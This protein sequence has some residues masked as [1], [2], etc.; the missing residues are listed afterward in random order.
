MQT[1]QSKFLNSIQPFAGWWVGLYFT[2]L[3]VIFTY[4][5]VWRMNNSVVGQIGD[6]IYFIWL[7]RWYNQAL[8][9]LHTN[10]FYIAHLNYP[11]GWYIATSDTVPAAMIYTLPLSWIGGATWAYNASMLLSFILSGLFMYL[12]IKESTG[13]RWSGLLSGTLFAFVP[14]HVEHFVA[15][16]LSLA[17]MQ[18]FPLYF[19]ALHRLLRAEQITWKPILVAAVS[20]GLISGTAPYYIYMT[21][22]FSAVFVLIWLWQE[23]NR[24]SRPVLWQNLALLGFIGSFLLLIPMLPYLLLNQEGGLASR[25]ME[26]ASRYSASPTDFI[27]PSTDHFLWGPWIVAHFDRSLVVEA[28]L[29]VGVVGGLLA[30]IA[31]IKLKETQAPDL[32]IPALWVIV[33]SVILALGTRLLWLNQQV[34]LHMPGFLQGVL[35]REATTIPL[36]GYFLFQYFP[37][38]DKMRALSRFGTFAQIWIFVLAGLGLAWLLKRVPTSRQNLVALVLLVL[39]MLDFYPGPYKNFARIDGRPVDYWLADQPGN[40]AVV[41]F[42]FSQSGDQDQLY[43]TA[44]HGKPYVGGYFSANKPPQYLKIQPVLDNFPSPEGVSLLYSLGVQYVIV[45]SKQYDDFPLV[46]AQIQKLGLELTQV[47]GGQYVYLLFFENRNVK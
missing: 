6:N 15:G 29:Y 37:F 7:I 10:P 12:W 43:N 28:T 45:D 24:L 32:V 39:A 31:L 34:V 26:Y 19:W 27:L 33:S 44:I 18:W 36:P 4:P 2:I 14:N 5:L 38:Y 20:L 40:G 1:L 8:F 22:L 23:R 47:V 25:S 41:Q 30:L 21:I 42:P 35:G 11:E 17:S 46:N 9:I 16:H 3:S 13:S